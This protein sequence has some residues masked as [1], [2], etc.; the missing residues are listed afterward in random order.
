[1]GLHVDPAAVCLLVAV[2]FAAG[3]LD[4]VVGGGGLVQV[5][6]LMLVLPGAPVA[7]VLGTNKLVA[8]TGTSGAAV[9]YV[10]RVGLDRRRALAAAALGLP[11]ALVGAVTA[12]HLPRDVITLVVAATL[13][14]VGVWA[15]VARPG[16][17][18]AGTAAAEGPPGTGCVPPAPPAADG[19]PAR[20][21][22]LVLAAGASVV[23]FYSGVVG[24][25]TGVLLVALF[26]SALGTDFLRGSAM[27][28]VVSIGSDLGALALFGALG[29]VLWLLGAGMA[30]ANVAGGIVG[31]RT[32]LARGAGF[33]R[34]VLLL[35]VVALVTKIV[36]DQ[37]LAA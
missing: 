35:V 28:K 29:H 4:A 7:T 27:A 17:A 16:R 21:P 36:C 20:R 19:V 24:S 13:V 3:W 10:S 9:T 23:G 26:V 33:V 8:I 31:A 15:V 14:G 18:S 5:P 37:W 1:M 11:T 2:A 34:A 22:A 30:V 12:S 32:A 6:A 25:G